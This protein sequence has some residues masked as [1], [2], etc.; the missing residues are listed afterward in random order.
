MVLLRQVSSLEHA[1][2]RVPRGQRRKPDSTPAPKSASS[3]QS[4]VTG[5]GTPRSPSGCS[6]P[7]AHVRDTP[8]PQTPPARLPGR[9]AA[10]PP[11]R[12][13]PLRARPPP[14]ALGACAR[15]HSKPCRTTHSGERESTSIAIPRPRRSTG[16]GSISGMAIAGCH[17]GPD[18]LVG[19]R[20]RA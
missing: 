4:R 9:P 10:C 11:A 12:A 20:V 19:Q 15:T 7:V 16:N 13:A 6:R 17:A 5:L 14:T 2:S 3:D 8:R 18:A 1:G